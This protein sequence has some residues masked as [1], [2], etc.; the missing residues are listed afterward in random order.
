MWYRLDFVDEEIFGPEN[1]S[2]PKNPDEVR[3]KNFLSKRYTH[4]LQ[5]DW[6]IGS[7]LTLNAALSY[8]DYQR[9]TRTTATDLATGE[10]WLT[11]GESEQDLTLYKALMA[12]VTAAWVVAPKLSLQPRCGVPAD[13][14]FGQSAR[15]R[16]ENRLCGVVPL[17]R[18]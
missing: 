11:D 10:K 16:S 13:R 2:N 6:K 17:C 15:R 8:Q 4:Q 14:G 5:A 12:R 18:V 9:R 3:D 1:P 7:R